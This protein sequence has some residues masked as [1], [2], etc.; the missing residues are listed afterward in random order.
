MEKMSD[1][2][3]IEF[4]QKMR[5]EGN[6]FDPKSPGVRKD[7][8]WGGNIICDITY[9]HEY[10]NS[11][12]DIYSQ[13]N[14]GK[15][16]RPTLIY[17]HGGG[18]MSGTKSDVYPHHDKGS[19][20][21]HVKTYMKAGFNVVS[22]GYALAHQFTYPT[23]IIQIG[24]AVKF[25]LKNA[26]VYGLDMSRIV[27]CG[28]SAG[29]QLAGQFINIQV[30]EVYANEM[31]IEPILDKNCIKAVI[32][33]SSLLDPERLDDTD[34]PDNNSV[35]GMCGRAYFVCNELKG[36][37]K[38]KQSSVI[39][40]VAKGFPPSFISDGNSGSFFDQAKDMAEKLNEL[41]IPYQLNTYPKEEVVLDHGRFE[42]YS[43]QYGKENMEKTIDFVKN[44]I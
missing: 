22:I 33:Q 3:R 34:S 13:P 40:Y 44:F 20:G 12:L 23:P 41:N 35:F 37:H 10:P 29:G 25:M 4:I 6:S 38:A 5:G 32:F 1:L 42:Q 30:N 18:Y 27:F 26:N 19:E 16:S 2:Q 14:T 43:T 8:P 36:S 11:F 17:I 31:G 9:D 28:L 39:T 21:W 7:L 15:T 24:Q